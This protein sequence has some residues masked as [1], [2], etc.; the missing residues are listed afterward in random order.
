[1]LLPLNFQLH[2]RRR[3]AADVDNL[4]DGYSSLGRNPLAI[5]TQSSDLAFN[6]AGPL[7]RL[8]LPPVDC[9]AHLAGRCGID[10]MAN[11]IA[12]G[13]TVINNKESGPALSGHRR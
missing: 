12:H 9:V 5:R 2:L 3:W 8:S 6:A 4:P 1:M 7:C 11:S 10:E 13:G